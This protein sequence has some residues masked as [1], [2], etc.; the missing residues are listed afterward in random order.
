MHKRDTIVD[1]RN[2]LLAV[3]ILAGVIAIIMGASLLFRKEQVAADICKDFIEGI[4]KG[5]ADTTYNMFSERAQEETT[6]ETWRSQVQSLAVV[7]GE[8]PPESITSDEAE[9]DDSAPTTQKYKIGSGSGP[10]IVECG[11]VATDNGTRV[12][13]F[14]SR[15]DN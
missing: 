1:M 14:T 8:V 9:A 15:P 3:G 7:Y 6:L 13:S 11:T 4:E 2:K 12:D 10:F 5:D